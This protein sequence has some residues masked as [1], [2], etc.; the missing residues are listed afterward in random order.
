MMF[1]RPMFTLI[2]VVI[3]VLGINRGTRSD[4]RLAR[5]R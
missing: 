5:A 1:A 3:C 2:H 4:F